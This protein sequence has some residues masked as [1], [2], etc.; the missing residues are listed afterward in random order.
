MDVAKIRVVADAVYSD[1]AKIQMP[2]PGTSGEPSSL[3]DEEKEL[4]R[5]FCLTEEQYKRIAK[6]YKSSI[7]S[8]DSSRPVIGI[9][10]TNHRC[11]YCGVKAERSENVCSHCGAPL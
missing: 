6:S 10:E 2:Y 5:M 9:A 4:A 3:S 8:S 1:N 7:V 11:E